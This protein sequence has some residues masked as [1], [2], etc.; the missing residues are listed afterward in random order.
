MANKRIT[1]ILMHYIPSIGG[2]ER[3]LHKNLEELAKIGH[4]CTGIGYLDSL[5]RPFPAK[6]KFNINGVNVLQEDFYGKKISIDYHISQSDAV[7]TGLTICPHVVQSCRKW[8]KPVFNFVCDEICFSNDFIREAIQMSDYVIAN[9][10]YMSGR[11]SEIGIKNKILMPFFN[12][13]KSDLNFK[14]EHVLFVYPNKHKG[15]DIVRY[16]AEQMPEIKFVIVGDYRFDF[17]QNSPVSKSTLPNI[18]YVGNVE[19]EK[20]MDELYQKSFLTLIPSQVKETFSMVAAESIY[21]KIPVIASNIGALPETVGCCGIIIEDYSN[22]DSWLRILRE[23]I[24]TVFNE[25]VF[26]KQIERFKNFSDIKIL[27]NLIQGFNGN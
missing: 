16:L 22:P 8:K 20:V 3:S 5:A 26:E 4:T 21:R 24:C 25:S 23:N 10:E 2:A 6:N 9:S 1:S 27:D 11:L 14:K 17:M 12:K 15:H 19:D 7:F 13:N 18:V